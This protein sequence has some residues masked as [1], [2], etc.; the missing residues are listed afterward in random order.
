MICTRRKREKKKG[1]IFLSV[2]FLQ[3][4]HIFAIRFQDLF[5]A[6]CFYQH[7]V[8]MTLATALKAL[9]DLVAEGEGA[10]N[11]FGRV[12]A[13]ANLIPPKFRYVLSSPRTSYLLIDGYGEMQSEYG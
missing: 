12:A 5:L 9:R 3:Q 8:R 11:D 7:S 2:S 1:R 6:L 4:I 10:V 13:A